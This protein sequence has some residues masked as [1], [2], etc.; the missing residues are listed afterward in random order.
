MSAV[1]QAIADNADFA[2][3]DVQTT[4]D[5]EVVVLHD[6][7]LMRMAGDSRRLRDLTLA[8]TKEVDVGK[9]FSGK[10]VGERIPTLTEVIGLARG[11]I[12]LNIELKYNWPDPELADKVV[13]LLRH[14]DFLTSCIITSLDAAALA[15][16]QRLA[17]E[18]RVGQIVTASV[19]NV[20][21][22]PGQILS[23]NKRAANRRFIQ[24]ART[25]GKEVHVWTLNQAGDMLLMIE[26]GAHNLITDYPDVAVRLLRKRAKLSDGEKLALSLR[27]LFGKAEAAPDN[28]NDP[29]LE[30]P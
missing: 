5:G 20:T 29:S 12:Q 22:L 15:K 11:K 7:D 30:S 17:P 21:G 1:R 13:E 24:R 6:G 25:A 10:F 27:V 26:R 8:E 18:L 14:E 16:V 23:V 4:A 19:G 3:I 9:K 2:E 28:A